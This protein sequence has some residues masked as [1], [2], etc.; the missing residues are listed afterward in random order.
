MRRVDSPRP[1][2]NTTAM[3]TAYKHWK[4]MPHGPFEQLESNL[5]RVEGSLPGHAL[6]RVMTVARRSDG[7][8]VVHSA[9]ALDEE[10]MARLD[11]EGPVAFLVIPNRFHRLDARVYKDRYPNAKVVCPRSAVRAVAKV[12][13]VDH[14]FDAYPSDPDVALQHLSGTQDREGVLIVRHQSRVTLVFNDAIFNAPHVPGFEGF[15]LRYV[16][17]STGAPRVSRIARLFLVKDRRAFAKGLADLA[18]TPGLV[19]IVVSHHEVIGERPDAVLA[20]I[21]AAQG[22]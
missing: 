1:P 9:I 21:A 4:V 15:V 22:A 14:T 12:V 3:G 13:P 8:L 11:H 17:Q 6:K 16:T 10:C 2:F 7:G 18:K 5:W 20:T 19:R